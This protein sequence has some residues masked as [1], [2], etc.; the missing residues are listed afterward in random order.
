M[1]SLGTLA[2]NIVAR[3]EKFTRG[4][5]QTLAGT[6][7]LKDGLMGTAAASQALTAALTVGATTTAVASGAFVAMYRE[8]APLIDSLG[9]TA[10]KIGATTEGL[11]G[12]HLAGE[13]GGLGMN[14]VNMASQRATRRIAEAASGTGEAVK[15]LEE[16]GINAE[17]INSL[18]LE[19]K[20]VVIADRMALVEDASDKLR[21]SFKLFDSEGAGLVNVIGNGSA[22]LR[23]AARDAAFFG[24]AL[25]RDAVAGVENTNDGLSRLST[26]ID[27]AQRQTVSWAS[28]FFQLDRFANELAIGIGAATGGR[29]RLADAARREAEQQ[30]RVAS[31]VERT[32]LAFVRRRA[33]QVEATSKAQAEANAAERAAD[34]SELSAQRS[35]LASLRQQNRN[36]G[37]SPEQAI[38]ANAQRSVLDPKVSEAIV[39]EATALEKLRIAKEQEADS[40]KK[41][42]SMAAKAE[43]IRQSVLTDAEKQAERIAEINKLAAA[44][45]LDAG[46]AARAIKQSG[47][48]ASIGP[49]E[50]TA[51]VA[52]SVDTFAALRRN[53]GDKTGETQVQIAKA[54]LKEQR[55]T[56]ELLAGRQPRV[57]SMG[58]AVT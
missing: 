5:S 35:L 25:S 54:Q 9:K 49:A 26:A 58:G 32:E 11:A 56:R 28:E 21:L 31:A 23:E 42:Q 41:R 2:V 6:G 36:F 14:T 55:K 52:G 22:G 1:A 16:L 18:P 17:A 12:L 20:M 7:R 39:R 57:Y 47:G 3:T 44:G 24:T 34:A 19:D 43:Q 10:D 4:V 46:L 45:I 29:Q 8:Q 51:R 33:V 50:L 38:V 53:T 37:L 15:A 27:G 48:V 30:E 13:L 40:D